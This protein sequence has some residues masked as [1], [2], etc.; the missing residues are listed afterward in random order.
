MS[1][2]EEVWKPVTGYE[3]YYEVSDQGRVRSVDR[4]TTTA[5]GHKRFYRG[6]AMATTVKNGYPYITL[7]RSGKQ[8]SFFVHRLVLIAFRGEA[9]D[10]MEAC[11]ND[12]DRSNPRIGNLRWDTRK[13]NHADK[14]EHGTVQHGEKNGFSRLTDDDVRKIRILVGLC[15][16]AELAQAF[17]VAKA[18]IEHVVRGKSWAHIPLDGSYA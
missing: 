1:K 16:R 7:Y 4:T 5:L 8:R 6:T 13:N 12:G 11:H 17:G 2:T 14:L 10:G 9:P 3:G 15:T 18:T